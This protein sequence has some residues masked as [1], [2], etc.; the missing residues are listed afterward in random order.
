M[1]I[2]IIALGSQGDVQPYIALGKG[3]KKA[4]HFVRLLTHENFEDLVNAH[5]LD[6]WAAKGN[7]QDVIQSKEMR[8][9]LEKGNFF[10]IQSQ[11]AKQGSRIA[12]DWAKD[13]LGACQGMNLILVGMGGMTLGLSLAEKLNIPL[14][15]AYVVPFTPTT[16]FPSVLLPKSLSRLGSSFNRFSHN[17]TRQFIWQPTRPGDKLA[18]KQV[19]DLPAAPF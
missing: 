3:L 1:R 18:R 15:Q 9:V 11:M 12:I 17:L 16:A 5:G 13:G 19:L 7:V 4:G 2:A 6:F 14:L 10:A 8:E